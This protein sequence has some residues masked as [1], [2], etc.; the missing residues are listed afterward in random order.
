MERWLIEAPVDREGQQ[1]QSAEKPSSDDEG[2]AESGNVAQ[3]LTM[4]TE[5]MHQ[6]SQLLQQL[7]IADVGNAANG[8]AKRRKC[9][10]A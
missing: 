1:I 9:R 4:V 7:F 2:Q 3:L 5:Q 8:N 6:Q 10:T